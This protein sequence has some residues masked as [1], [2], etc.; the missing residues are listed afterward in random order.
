MKRKTNEQF[1]QDVYDLVGDE[2]TFLDDYVNTLTKL[3]VKHNKCGNTYEVTPGNFLSGKRCPYCENKAKRKTN[4]QFKQDVFDLVGNEYVFLDKYVNTRT[5]LR[6]K[7]SKCNNIYKVTPNAF[8]RGSR[9]PY[10]SNNAKKTNEDF[11]QEVFDLVG[12][13]YTFLECYQGASTKIKVKHNKCGHTYEVTPTHFL[14]GERCSYCY[15]TPKKTDSQF[16]REIF[17]LV[18]NEYVFLDPYVT[19][20]TKMRVKHNKCGHIYEIR[21]TDF[22]SHHNRCPYCNIPKGE[23]IIDKLLKSLGIK[24][25]YQK[26]FE[27]LKDTQLLSYDFYIIDQNILIEYQGQQHYEPVDYFGGGSKFKLQQKHDKLKSDYARDHGYNLI[28]VPY[29][30]DTLSKIKKYLIKH[31]LRK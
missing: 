14:T 11:K 13:E 22:I 10:C 25:E 26:T 7:H 16:K 21:P 1:Q 20:K 3:R 17:D 28:A 8:L 27:D 24:Y 9:C 31:G 12:D 19:N 29:T 18:G 23:Y 4:D 15:G 5:K 2:Y 30:C 6:V